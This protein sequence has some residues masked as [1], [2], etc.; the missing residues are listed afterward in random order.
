MDHRSRSAGVV[1][2]R[3]QALDR[4]RTVAS[5]RGTIDRTVLVTGPRGSGRTTLLAEALA[6]L[7]ADLLWFVGSPTEGPVPWAAARSTAPAVRAVGANHAGGRDLVDD[8]ARGEL[9]PAELGLLLAES[10]RSMPRRPRP[11]VVVGDDFQAADAESLELLL[12]LAHRNQTFD[13]SYVLACPDDDLPDAAADLPRVELGGLDQV[14]ARDALAGWTGC[15]VTSPVAAVLTAAT[16]GV[17]LLLREVGGQLSADQLEGRRALPTPLPATA[18]TLAAVAPVLDRLA[19]DDRRALAAFALG[20]GMPAG[21][22]E[23]VAGPGAVGSLLRAHL[24]ESVPGGYRPTRNALGWLADATLENADQR[25]LAG[26]LAA[27]WS[28]LDPVRSALHAERAGGEDD[29][30]LAVGRRTLATATPTTDDRLAEALAWAVVGHADPPRRATGS[31]SPP[32]PSVP[33]TCSTP[34]TPSSAPSSRPPWRSPTCPSSR[35]GAG[36]SARWPTTVRSPRRRPS[37]SRR[38]S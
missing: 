20:T 25:A 35:G 16:D 18:A 14:A 7:D 4:V 22:L 32:A 19:S 31:S 34:A 38:W 2:S 5:N 26:A 23:Q 30:V 37:C 21:V 15:D 33:A 27:A 8:A 24:V 17:P 6:D 10:Y 3:A 13:V 28:A 1:G 29:E 11:V 12:F 9:S 36:S